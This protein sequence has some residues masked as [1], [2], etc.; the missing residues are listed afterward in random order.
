MISFACRCGIA[1]LPYQNEE[2]ICFW[3]PIIVETNFHKHYLVKVLTKGGG[4]VKNLIKFLTSFMN[5]LL[6]PIS[7]VKTAQ[8]PKKFNVDLSNRPQVVVYLFSSHSS[9][10]VNWGTICFAYQDFCCLCIFSSEGWR[11]NCFP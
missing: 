10:P 8:P 11:F 3:I 2:I 1:A 4:G 9:I 6:K 7:W 5:G